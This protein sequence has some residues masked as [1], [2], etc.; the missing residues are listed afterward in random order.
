[1]TTGEIETKEKQNRDSKL[2]ER[3]QLEFTPESIQRLER[4]RNRA[5]ANTR[6]E[7][8][9]NAIRLYDWF[10]SETEPDTTI[11]LTDANG[12]LISVFKARLLHDGL[13]SK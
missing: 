3:V 2:K 8:I 4:M 11:T 10:I 12:K 13:T 1:M 7:V 5:G 6:A 9:R